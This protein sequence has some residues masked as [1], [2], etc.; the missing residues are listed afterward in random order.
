MLSPIDPQ[1]AREPGHPGRTAV[2]LAVLTALAAAAGTVQAQEAPASSSSD[3]AVQE[4][5]VTGSYIHR[6]D[7]ETAAPVQIITAADLKESGYT[8]VQQVLQ[9]LTAN[10]QGTLSQGFSGAFAQGAAGIA[11]RGLNVGYTLVLIDGHRS[12]P[13]PIGDDGVRSFVD[14]A[15]LPLDAI[16]H[17]DVLKDGASSTYGSD[18]IAGVVNIVL[19]KSFQGVQLTADGG[20]S[21]HNDGSNV[22]LS[23][24]AGIGDLDSDG[25]NAYISAEFRKQNPIRFADRGGFLSQTNYSAEGGLDVTPGAPNILNGGFPTSGTG[26]VVN[27]TTS[28]IE[29]FMPGCGPSGATLSQSL[30]AFNAGQCTFNDTWDFVQPPTSNT[31]LT[32]KLSKR[33]FSN[34]TATLDLGYFDSQAA[35]ANGP[36]ESFPNGYSGVAFGP[37]IPAHAVATIAPTTIPSTNPSY[38]GT[39]S[40]AADLLYYA[41]TDLGP[42]TSYSNSKTY[43]AVANLDGKIGEWNVNVAAGYTEVDL[44]IWSYNEVEAGALQTALDSTTDPFLVGQINSPSVINEIAPPLNMY[45]DSKLAFGHAGVDRSLVDLLGGPLALAFGTDYYTRD[46]YQVAAEQ[47]QEGLVTANNNF[48]IGEQYVYAGYAELDAP[49]LKQLDLDAAVRYDHYNLS[50]GKAS[51]KISFKYTPVEEFAIRGTA[52][53]GFRAPGPAENGTAGQS[54][55]AGDTTDPILCPN[56]TN[57][58]AAG[59]FAG[60]CKIAYA[61]VQTTNPNLKPETSNNFT[62]GFIFQPI[63]DFTASWELYDIKIDNQIVSGGPGGFVRSTNLSPIP[64]YNA[65]GGTT[66]VAPPVGPI[67]YYETSYINANSTETNG[68]DLDL[69]YQHHFDWF[70]FKSEA[71]W[72]YINKWDITIDGVTYKEAGTHGP[73][74]YSG[75]TG[76]PRSKVEWSNTA[77]VGKFSITATANFTSSFSSTDPS[78]AAFFGEPGDTCYEYLDAGA[79][80]ST[81]YYENVFAAGNIPNSSMCRVAHFMTVNLYAKYQVSDNFDIHGSIINAFNAGAPVDWGTYAGGAL[82]IPYNPSLFTDGAVGPTFTLGATL[83][84]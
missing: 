81:V 74:D 24:I 84:F 66:L 33:L 59:N 30:A 41:F 49:V 67:L 2:R 31:N 32:A 39:A 72:T 29:G 68:F 54:F 50:G 60:Q 37:G 46:Q 36:A 34:W 17:I 3:Q 62:F 14:V 18:A 48:T 58:T 47:V 22:H 56:P 77:T 69:T 20:D 44:N 78:I 11:L 15:N 65:S 61:T 64:E 43:R 40:G 35:Q 10:G 19:K 28:A 71:M 75:D 4:V 1:Q 13:Y 55:F 27:P 70:D 52:S 79:F 9:N 73:A 6:T 12:A 57:A 82:A 7:T 38:P 23:G 42:Q 5:V 16:D 25:Y 63:H 45:G 8:T 26:Y 83:K 21:S 80:S 53:K 76:N 51:P